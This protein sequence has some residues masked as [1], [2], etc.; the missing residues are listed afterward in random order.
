MCYGTR[1]K[2]LHSF[3]P[4]HV[5]AFRL[6]LWMTVDVVSHIKSKSQW[7]EVARHTLFLIAPVLRFALISS[8]ALSGETKLSSSL[9]TNRPMTN[10]HAEYL[11]WQHTICHLKH[12]PSLSQG[13]WKRLLPHSERNGS[14]R[15]GA[16]VFGR[17]G[18]ST[19]TSRWEGVHEWWVEWGWGFLLL[20][21]F[22]TTVWNK[23]Y[24]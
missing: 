16:F 8:W 2:G 6:C 12:L 9:V 18:C 22:E 14:T 5:G 23:L 7:T 11:K 24:E 15:D 4:L 17:N 19:G 1:S 13:L 21:L 3:Y 10:E 20:H